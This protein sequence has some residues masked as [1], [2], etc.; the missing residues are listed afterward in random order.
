M[1][2]QQLERHRLRPELAVDLD[3][4]D[5]VMVELA[6]LDERLDFES[7]RQ[8]ARLEVE[9][10]LLGSRSMSVTSRVDAG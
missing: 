2:M 7:L 8:D 6:E 1:R 3:A 10:R 9:D 5:V 4:D